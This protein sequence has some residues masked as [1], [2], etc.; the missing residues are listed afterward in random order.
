MALSAPAWLEDRA[1]LQDEASGWTGI[2]LDDLAL[3]SGLASVAPAGAAFSMPSLVLHSAMD[4]HAHAHRCFV[5]TAGSTLSL[6]SGADFQCVSGAQMRLLARH[7][8]CGHVGGGGAVW[9]A[10]AGDFSWKTM[11]GAFRVASSGPVLLTSSNAGIR[12]AAAQSIELQAGGARICL[13]DGQVQ[14]HAPGGLDFRGTRKTMSGPVS[15]VSDLPHLD[16]QPDAHAPVRRLLRC[17]SMEGL[18]MPGNRIKIAPPL[19]DPMHGRALMG[20]GVWTSDCERLDDVGGEQ[21][22]EPGECPVE[23]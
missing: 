17:V 12:L 11:Q 9:V 19:G 2:A 14:I 6:Q 16:G 22:W 20:H 4:A 18:P 5:Q 1:A 3:P 23:S 15:H 10:Q 8:L 21:D 7:G 13:T